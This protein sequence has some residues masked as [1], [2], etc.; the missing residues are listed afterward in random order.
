[1]I[2]PLKDAVASSCGGKAGILGILLRHG[3]PVPD[4]FVVTFDAYRSAARGLNLDSPAGESSGLD[5]TQH[6]METLPLPAELRAQ[7]A[8]RLNEFGHPPVAVRSSGDNEDTV[9]RSGAGQHESVLGVRG[10]TEVADA[11]RATWASLHS[12]RAIGYRGAFGEDQISGDPTMAV[13]IQRLVNAEVSGVMFTPA[14]PDGTTKIEASWGLGPSVVGGAVTP[15]AYRVAADGTI[16]GTIATKQT[17][18]DRVGTQ[19]ATT[20]VPARSRHRPSLDD[21]TLTRLSRLGQK[22]AAVLAGPQDVEWALTGDRLWILQARP[23]TATAPPTPSGAPAV[24]PCT[25]T[26]TPA[27]PGAVTGTARIVRGPDDFTRVQAGDILICPYTDPAWT[28]LLRHAAGVVTETGGALS[29][30][31]IVARELRIPAVLGIPNATTTIHDGTDI[32][33]DGATGAVTTTV[34]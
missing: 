24:A 31:A 1:M 11:I 27:S 7:L 32:T 10:V 2:I 21:A 29:H 18:I 16:T 8:R 28:P 22:I 26:G 6:L 5:A 34:T 14:S 19:L 20:T 4:G 13:L 15:D 25:V 23:I 9:D 33:I 17:R 12:A 3:L 30:A